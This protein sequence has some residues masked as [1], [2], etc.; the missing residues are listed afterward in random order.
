VR[1]S[2]PALQRDWGLR[3]H[4]TDNPELLCYSKR[5]ADGT[6]L[7]VVVVNVDPFHMQHGFIELPFAGWGLRPTDPLRVH[8][9]LSDE[10]YTWRGARNYVRL[11]PVS[12][13]AHILLVE[14]DEP[15][16]PE[17]ALED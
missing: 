11:D 12:R 14:L 8:D 2:H 13:V 9:L 7:V 5:S 15:L 6:D 16:P 10:R 1:R 4:P 3:F 17:P